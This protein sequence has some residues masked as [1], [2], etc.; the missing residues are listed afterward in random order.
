MEKG[1][2]KASATKSN[3]LRQSGMD[4]LSLSSSSSFFFEKQRKPFRRLN[5]GGN[6]VGFHG[7]SELLE[8]LGTIDQLEELDISHTNPF[9]HASQAFAEA[10]SSSILTQSSK[11]AVIDLSQNLLGDNA[12]VIFLTYLYPLPALREVSFSGN[13]L[14]DVFLSKLN[15]TKF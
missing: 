6:P 9:F 14:G 13:H 1:A 8:G 7:I 15:L 12:A 3:L 2:G 4:S 5:L 10:L 11:L